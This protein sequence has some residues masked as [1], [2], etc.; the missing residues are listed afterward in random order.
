MTKTKK[1]QQLNDVLRTTFAGRILLTRNVQALSPEKQNILLNKV[2]TFSD[3]TPDNDPYN[4]HDF[5]AINLWN[6]KYFWK[7]DYYAVDN[8]TLSPDPSDETVTNRV[9]TIMNGKEY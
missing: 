2:K 7:I 8:E 4:E 3:L 9:L 6:E 5:G 1:I